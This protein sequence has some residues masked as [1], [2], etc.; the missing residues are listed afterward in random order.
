[1]KPMKRF[2]LLLAVFLLPALVAVA[3]ESSNQSVFQMRLVVDQPSADSEP[4]ILS[5][6]N[7]VSA[8][9]AL[10]KLNVEKKVLIDQSAIKSASVAKMQ[11]AGSLEVEFQ[12]EFIFT[13]EGQK[14]FAKITRENIDRRL[15]I[16]VDGKVLTA[17]VIRT[18][19]PGGRG[20]I[21]GD[22]TEQ[23]AKEIVAK[24]NPT[25]R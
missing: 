16:I 23:E 11:M 22:F 17:P 6:K 13:V 4:M 1:M 25:S 14:S 21:N 7:K 15:A 2:I 12:I 24:I 3:G 19:I 20:Q 18:E 10:E 9:P 5:H 8:Q